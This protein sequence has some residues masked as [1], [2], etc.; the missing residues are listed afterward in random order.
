MKALFD[1]VNALTGGLLT[2]VRYVIWLVSGISTLTMTMFESIDIV[3]DVLGFFPHTIS[4][5]LIAMLGG[6]VV[7]RILGRS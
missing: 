1:V 7:F 6:L 2:I 4:S 5:T 3:G